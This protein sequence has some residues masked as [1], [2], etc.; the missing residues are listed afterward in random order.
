MFPEL[1]GDSSLAGDF[2]IHSFY[3]EKRPQAG[4]ITAP[5]P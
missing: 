3:R 5:G 2:C 4:F 1:T